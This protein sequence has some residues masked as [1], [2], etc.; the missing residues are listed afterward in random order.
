MYFFLFWSPGLV[1]YGKDFEKLHKYVVSRQI[2]NGIE[3]KQTKTKNQIRFFY[4]RQWQKLSKLVNMEAFT[5]NV[6]KDVQELSVLINF[7]ELRKK[8]GGGPQGAG[9]GGAGGTGANFLNDKKAVKL[10]ELIFKGQ[11]TLKIGGKMV[12]L[13]TPVT[14]VLRRNVTDDADGLKTEEALHGVPKPLPPLPK[15]IKITLTPKLNSDH[16]YVN[17]ICE[18]NPFLKM[19][20]SPQKPLQSVIDFLERKWKPVG[21]GKEVAPKIRI[22]PMPDVAFT[23]FELEKARKVKEDAGNAAT[24]NEAVV[25]A[26]AAAEKSP[27][28]SGDP[29]TVETTAKIT[30]ITSLSDNACSGET[31]TADTA[32]AVIASSAPTQDIINVRFKAKPKRSRTL[33]ERSDKS[34]EDHQR[35]SFEELSWSSIDGESNMIVGDLFVMLQTPQVLQLQYSFDETPLTKKTT[36]EGTLYQYKDKHF[37]LALSRLLNVASI[38]YLNEKEKSKQDSLGKQTCRQ[39]GSVKAQTGGGLNSPSTSSVRGSPSTAGNV[40]RR[41]TK[42]SF[43]ADGCP[44]TPKGRKAQLAKTINNSPGTQNSSLNG[45]G[46][47]SGENGVTTPAINPIFAIPTAIPL[48]SKSNSRSS[49]QYVGVDNGAPSTSNGES[50]RSTT[51]QELQYAEALAYKEQLDNLKRSQEVIQATRT[52]MKSRHRPQG[53]SRKPIVVQRMLTSRPN[54]SVV[55]AS[56]ATS[57]VVGISS[58]GNYVSFSLMPVV[59]NAIQMSTTTCANQVTGAVSVLPSTILSSENGEAV[60][61]P[62][63]NSSE[64]LSGDILQNALNAAAIPSSAESDHDDGGTVQIAMDTTAPIQTIYDAATVSASDQV[65]YVEPSVSQ[66]NTPNRVSGAGHVGG[67]NEE[68]PNLSA[69]LND[70]SLPEPDSLQNTSFSEIMESGGGE[71]KNQTSFTEA[72]MLPRPTRQSSP[73]KYSSIELEFLPKT[74]TKNGAGSGNHHKNGGGDQLLETPFKSGMGLETPTKP[75][76]MDTPGRKLFDT[77]Y[78]GSSS[79]DHILSWLGSSDE[80]LTV[81][82]SNLPNLLMTEDS[83]PPQTRNGKSYQGGATNND[84]G[85]HDASGPFYSSVTTASS[86]SSSST[87]ASLSFLNENSRDSIISNS[88]VDFSLHS[89]LNENSMDYVNKFADL[90]SHIS[91][92]VAAANNHNLETPKKSK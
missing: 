50:T 74:P 10:N 15:R 86:S 6:K 9:G 92:G 56:T 89:L 61:L 72:L 67:A 33:S 34:V 65:P 64:I 75:S 73:K 51:V 35:Q 54:H 12:R 47:I 84:R 83:N 78:K 68:S 82:D 85:N 59:S 88:S 81:T 90:A 63:E 24:S 3:D 53:G 5:D 16:S 91:G 23:I 42:T 22:H 70:V 71:G 79:S 29:S 41:V 66:E 26:E 38:E 19:D 32:P 8:C 39:C 36:H 40:R 1:E 76:M 57:N 13:K 58:Q 46:S 49:R 37:G 62:V 31:P 44:T 17:H 30:E 2:K 60:R 80:D 69:L 48:K 52:Q 28:N 4:Y 87:T 18:Q 14:P 45:N 55:G 27:I 11:T 21:G 25:T 20:V 43:A 77:P 7:G